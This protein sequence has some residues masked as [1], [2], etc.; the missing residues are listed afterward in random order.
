MSLGLCSKFEALVLCLFDILFLSYAIYFSGCLA[1]WL[2]GW[3]VGRLCLC[4]FLRSIRG[5]VGTSLK[6]L[7]H[8]GTLG[9]HVGT[10]AINFGVGH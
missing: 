10:I 8:F 7:G 3:L 2:V 1:S 4:V 5:D 6:H 9:V